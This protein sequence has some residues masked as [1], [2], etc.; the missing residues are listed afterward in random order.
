MQRPL[1]KPGFKGQRTNG[2]IA[3]RISLH[4][5]LQ[6]ANCLVSGRGRAKGPIIALFPA[7]RID[8]HLAAGA[9]NDSWT[10]PATDQVNSKVNPGHDTS[11]GYDVVVI[12]QD[13]L[14]ME[15]HFRES[16]SELGLKCPMGC[17]LPTVQNSCM[18]Q[19][20]TACTGRTNDRSCKMLFLDP[21]VQMP[22][23][24]SSNTRQVGWQNDGICTVGVNDQRG[25]QNLVADLLFCI[26]F[27]QPVRHIEHLAQSEQG[28]LLGTFIGNDRNCWRISHFF[29]HIRQS[30]L[31]CEAP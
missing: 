28:G 9:R 26:F 12:Q 13:M 15:L 5:K 20:E 19:P 24:V 10:Q 1:G 2:Q 7:C 8:K 29:C 11:R 31:C 27:N 3:V 25:R 30:Y 4:P 18:P 16:R 14:R 6:A 17:C 21:V 23:C 22:I